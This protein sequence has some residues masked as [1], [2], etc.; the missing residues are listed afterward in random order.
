LLIA[1]QVERRGAA[2]DHQTGPEAARDA[3]ESPARIARGAQGRV[4]AGAQ[5]GVHATGVVRQRGGVLALGPAAFAL[6][7]GQQGIELGIALRG[8]GVAERVEVAP[9]RG[10]GSAGSGRSNQGGNPQAHGEPSIGQRRSASQRERRAR[11]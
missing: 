9:G 6:A 3:G 8:H 4:D 1:R 7:G 5:Q 11:S 2:P 10:A